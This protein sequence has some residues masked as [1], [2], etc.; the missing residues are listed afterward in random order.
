MATGQGN[1]LS[2]ISMGLRLGHK[3]RQ[4]SFFGF[5]T[6]DLVVANVPRGK[7]AGYYCGRVACRKSGSFN[8]QTATEVIQGINHKYC[9]PIYKSDGYKY[10]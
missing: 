6:G 5:Q 8:I 4:K 7:K 10:N 1:G 3:P 9:Q 2:L